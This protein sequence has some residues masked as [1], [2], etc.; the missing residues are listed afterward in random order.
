M[1]IVIVANPHKAD[2]IAASRQV[3][4]LL[5]ARAEVRVLVEPDA[6]ALAAAAPELIVVLGGDGTVL[7]IAQA[8]QN[9]D[10]RVVG[11]NFGKLGYLTSYQLD[12]F[13]AHAD[14]ILAGH[15]PVSARLMLEGTS[16]R[17]IVREDGTVDPGTAKVSRAVYCHSA[18]NDIVINAGDPFRMIELQV[19]VNGQAAA[20]FSGD[21]L[22]ISTSSGSTGYNLSAGG[23]LI[24]PEVHAMVL[25][26]ICAHSLSFRP[27]VVSDGATI[28]VQP[29]RVNEG[30]RVSF[31]G[32]N[33]QPMT[34]QDALVIRRAQRPLQ[35]VEHPKMS[36]WQRLASKLLWAQTSW[37]SD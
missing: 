18:L 14:E 28:I 6:A 16:H 22:V 19:Y 21:G 17:N 7:R 33:P 20:R 13:I 37:H 32:L 11:I 31:D 10:A 29:R 1:R 12:E 8:V 25:T 4:K 15:V 3:E 23:P 9:L 26:P 30:T 24:T 36:H 35:L 34:G 2:A 27:V 5:A